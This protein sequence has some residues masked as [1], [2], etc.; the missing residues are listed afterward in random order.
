MHMVSFAFFFFYCR[1]CCCGWCCGC[2][3]CGRALNDAFPACL[4]D[5]KRA[6]QYARDNAARYGGDASF[7]VASGGSAGGHLALLLTLTS[8]RHVSELQPGFERADCSVQAGVTLYA[9]T[10]LGKD[11]SDDDNQLERWLERIVVKQ[12]KSEARR[13]FELL[14]PMWHVREQSVRDNAPLLMVHGSNDA[15]VPIDQPQRFVGELRARGASPER[16]LLLEVD[17][18]QHGFDLT[19]TPKSAAIN[20]F[21]HKWTRHWHAR[22]SHTPND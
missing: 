4:I 12:K 21:V 22:L 1:C 10:D 14:D 9:P 5:L 2:W 7:V 18:A 13:L 3:C 17:G 15:L 8:R 16:A 20:R 6:V 19:A 11:A